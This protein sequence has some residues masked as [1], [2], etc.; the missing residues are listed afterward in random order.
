MS[1]KPEHD[2]DNLIEKYQPLDFTA[3]EEIYGKKMLNKFKQVQNSNFIGK[4]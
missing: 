4:S 2:V 3:E 1:F